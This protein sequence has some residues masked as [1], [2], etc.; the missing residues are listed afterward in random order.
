MDCRRS[1]RI[2]GDHRA[3]EQDLGCAV[4]LGH[5]EQRHLARGRQGEE[6]VGLIG[7]VDIDAV[8]RDVL[9]LGDDHRTLNI[10]AELV[11]DKPE[12]LGHA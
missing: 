10:R 7:E 8:E 12:M 2:F 4:I 5:L 9:F 3:L 1:R 11:A 6:P